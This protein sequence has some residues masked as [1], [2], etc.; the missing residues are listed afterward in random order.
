MQTKSNMMSIVYKGQGFSTSHST[1]HIT[2]VTLWS[3]L[4]IRHSRH[5]TMI[6]TILQHSASETTFPRPASVVSSWLSSTEY[7]DIW[8]NDP[9]EQSA[10]STTPISLN[11]ELGYVKAF[12]TLPN[13]KTLP[14]AISFNNLERWRA[15]LV[16]YLNPD[17]LFRFLV[18]VVGIVPSAS[19]IC[20]IS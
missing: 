14:F 18:T 1:L 2:I 12:R 19:L 17:P 8:P 15:F 3:K 11:N 13:S 16:Q 20:S 5:D 4:R 10:R 6:L 9:V 7:R